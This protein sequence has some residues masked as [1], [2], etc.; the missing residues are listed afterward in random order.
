MMAD[1]ACSCLL[2]AWQEV[3]TVTRDEPA[4]TPKVEPGCAVTCTLVGC[5]LLVACL[6]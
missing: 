6:L 5:I 1:H 2:L 4:A 3:Q